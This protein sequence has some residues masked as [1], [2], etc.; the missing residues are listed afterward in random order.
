MRLVINTAT[1]PLRKV[2]VGI[3]VDIGV[4]AGVELGFKADLGW[5]GFSHGSGPWSCSTSSGKAP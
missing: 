2:F 4:K 3:E 1:P 5:F